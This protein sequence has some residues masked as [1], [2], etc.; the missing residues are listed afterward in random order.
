LDRE[1]DGVS[2][3]RSWSSTSTEWWSMPMI[4]EYDA[5]SS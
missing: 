3:S 5:V 4:W 1:A 2:A